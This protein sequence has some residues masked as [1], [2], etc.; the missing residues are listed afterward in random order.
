ML[1]SHYKLNDFLILLTETLSYFFYRENARGI[2]Y[3]VVYKIIL[4]PCICNKII[5]IIIIFFS[6][7][8]VTHHLIARQGFITL[9]P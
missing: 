8:E 7:N 4:F 3:D 2:M 6:Y 9:F 1:D 5:N